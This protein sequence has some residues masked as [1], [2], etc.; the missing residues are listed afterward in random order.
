LSTGST[1]SRSAQN[2]AIN[3]PRQSKTAAVPTLR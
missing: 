2:R 3:V 1:E